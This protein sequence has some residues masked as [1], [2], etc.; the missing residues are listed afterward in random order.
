MTFARLGALSTRQHEPSGA[1]RSFDRDRDG[2]V[3]SEGAAVLVLERGN[4]ARARGATAHGVVAGYGASAD[5]HHP[6]NPHPD[7][8]GLQQAIR[9]ALADAALTPGDIDHVSAHAASTRAGD[10]AEARALSHVFSSTPPPVT[11]L[12]SLLGHSLGAASA[13]QAACA[14]LALRHQAIPPT[15]NLDNQDDAID[16]DIVRKAPRPARLR[17]ILTT[18]CGFGGANAALILRGS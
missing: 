18:A 10:L 13:I 11:A 6:V 1:S 4:H 5:V 17:T 9:T 3:L 14:L 8:R 16:L 12:K 7:G 15:A 2:F